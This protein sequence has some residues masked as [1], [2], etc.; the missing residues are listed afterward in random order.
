MARIYPNIRQFID[1]KKLVVLR[2]KGTDKAVNSSFSEYGLQFTTDT[3][4]N[5]I[6]FMNAKPV[7]VGSKVEFV[8]DTR[9]SDKYYVEH[10]VPK[11][12]EDPRDDLSIPR[13]RF[14]KRKISAY[15][16]LQV[17]EYM[18]TDKA[19]RLLYHVENS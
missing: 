18:W 3:S 17:A 2:E 11:D 12:R 16:R 6:Y 9:P 15:L 19:Y 14:F 4:G 8:G 13:D 10:F 1:D 7:V 5:Y